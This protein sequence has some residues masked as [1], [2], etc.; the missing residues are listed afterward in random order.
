ML[1]SLIIIVLESCV[2][3]STTKP[4]NTTNMTSSAVLERLMLQ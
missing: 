3:C 2:S 4:A 1:R